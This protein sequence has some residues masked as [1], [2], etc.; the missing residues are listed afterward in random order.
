MPLPKKSTKKKKRIVK[1]KKKVVK[2][3]TAD[4]EKR[5]SKPSVP[6]RVSTVSPLRAGKPAD[7]SKKPWLGMMIEKDTLDKVVLTGVFGKGPAAAAGFGDDDVLINFGG[8]VVTDVAS[9]NTAFKAH[10][11]VGA[12]VAVRFLK[13]GNPNLPVDTTLSVMSQAD[14]ETFNEES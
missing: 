13:D 2:K 11:K 3:D 12:S 14:R 4:E 1:R 6:G 8:Q 7:P 9:F 10:A 5:T